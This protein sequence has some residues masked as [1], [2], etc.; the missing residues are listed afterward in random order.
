MKLGR[1]LAPCPVG[2]RDRDH[3]AP[4]ACVCEPHDVLCHELGLSERAC[5]A[6]KRD[7]TLGLGRPLLSREELADH[8]RELG[9]S[10]RGARRLVLLQG[11]VHVVDAC[12]LDDARQHA[13]GQQGGLGVDR[14]AH[15]R[16][17]RVTR[18]VDDELAL[19]SW[20]AREA[21]DHEG[22]Q[23]DLFF[24][25]TRNDPTRRLAL[26]DVAHA[27]D[28]P[29][30]AADKS[31]RRHLGIAEAQQG[32]GNPIRLPRRIERKPGIGIAGE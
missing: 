3:D 32:G 15:E 11:D 29:R 20:H 24:R 13:L 18:E 21:R 7:R 10:L 19:G 22:R 26:L 12:R 4:G 6:Q 5:G 28:E 17:R 14:N 1:E 8:R 27:V 25:E 2:I 23:C 9:V 16:D 31:H 30:I